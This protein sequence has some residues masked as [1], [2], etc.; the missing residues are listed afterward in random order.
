MSRL[1]FIMEKNSIIMPALSKGTAIEDQGN[2]EV[3]SLGDT[4]L[5]PSYF[6]EDVIN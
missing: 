5:G 3:W 4:F 6:F 2:R 1:L